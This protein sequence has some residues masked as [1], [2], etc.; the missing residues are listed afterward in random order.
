MLSNVLGVSSIVLILILLTFD[1]SLLFSLTCFYLAVIGRVLLFFL[2][3]SK[4]IVTKK[5]YTM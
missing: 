5:Q 1:S 4:L 2:Q 3:F